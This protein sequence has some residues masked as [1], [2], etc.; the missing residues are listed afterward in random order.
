M[1]E[2]TRPVKANRDATDIKDFWLENDSLARSRVSIILHL[3]RPIMPRKAD[4]KASIALA[5]QSFSSSF[6]V[7]EE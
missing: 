4:S 6:Y 5:A 2:T 1:Q 7:A 3:A